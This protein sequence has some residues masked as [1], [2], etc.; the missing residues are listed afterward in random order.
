LRSFLYFEAGISRRPLPGFGLKLDGLQP[1]LMLASDLR[2]LAITVGYD[3]FEEPR[4][5]DDFGIGHTTYNPA[6]TCDN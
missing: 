1:R 2:Q 5:N 3:S 6:H 4:T